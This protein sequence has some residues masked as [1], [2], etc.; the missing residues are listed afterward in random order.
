[1]QARPGYLR[2]RHEEG[3]RSPSSRPFSFPQGCSQ[4]QADESDTVLRT[5]V[6]G[7]YAPWRRICTPD[8]SDQ[9]CPLDGVYRPSPECLLN[10]SSG[11]IIGAGTKKAADWE[12]QS[13]AQVWLD[14]FL[15]SSVMPAVALFF[16]S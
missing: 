13:A 9:D 2:R 6:P 10:E 3:R 11:S 15:L 4:L 1:R 8:G 7:L 5:R 14:Y 16:F 12:I